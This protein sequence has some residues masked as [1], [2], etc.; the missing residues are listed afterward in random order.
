MIYPNSVFEECAHNRTFTTPSRETQDM[1]R[2]VAQQLREKLAGLAKQYY[3][4]KDGGA[5][6]HHNHRSSRSSAS[7]S[8]SA[9]SSFTKPS[10]SV[11]PH[12]DYKSHVSI[13]GNVTTGFDSQ[14]SLIRTYLN[15]TTDKTRPDMYTK[16]T[17]ILDQIIHPEAI[18]ENMDRLAT[19]V[20]QLSSLNKF[21]SVLFADMYVHLI[22]GY[23]VLRD[24][25]DKQVNK[26]CDLS[27][28]DTMAI[29][30]EETNYEDM[31]KNN[32]TNDGLRAETLFL[33]NVL[34]KLNQI[35][36]A[37]QPIYGLLNRIGES[38]EDSTAKDKNAE[39]IEHVFLIYKAMYV[40]E[41][42]DKEKEGVYSNIQMI[43]NYK[44]RE[45][46]GLTNKLVFKCME[47]IEM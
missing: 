2:D 29:N 1:V 44:A 12:I 43:A 22:D 3:A 9:S 23:P 15:K 38:K 40:A 27:M 11:P 6:S 45:N 10:S 34:I 39:F 35:E 18:P 19:T 16:I 17:N 24:A 31:C 37:K 14:L 42:I 32:K 5:S 28:Y 8:T 41:L 47:M 36:R 26:F 33:T 7:A 20:Y 30:T 13:L 4:I 25:F 21:Y 46:P